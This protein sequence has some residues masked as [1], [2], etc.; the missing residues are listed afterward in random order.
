MCP[1]TWK[2]GPGKTSIFTYFKQCFL[3][4]SEQNYDL[5]INWKCENFKNINHYRHNLYKPYIWYEDFT[6]FTRA[7]SWFPFLD[8]PLKNLQGISYFEFQKVFATKFLAGN[9]TLTKYHYQNYE[10]DLQN[11]VKYV[12]DFNRDCFFVW[13]LHSLILET[14][15]T[16]LN[17]SVASACILLSFIETELSLCKS[18]SKFENFSLYIILKERSCNLLNLLRITAVEHPNSSTLIELSFKKRIYKNT[19]FRQFH[20]IC[21]SC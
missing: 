13:K 3:K 4:Y 17:I 1:S 8:L 11:I 5:H 6:N 15:L 20:I 18:S 2:C 9:T 16:T 21:Y 19:C 10:L 12:L 7:V 14:P